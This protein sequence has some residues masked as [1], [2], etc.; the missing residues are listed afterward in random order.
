[1][2]LTEFKAS[3]KKSKLL[4]VIG[5]ISP[6]IPRKLRNIPQLFVDGGCKLKK[7]HTY[8]SPDSFSLGDGDSHSKNLLDHILPSKKDYSDFRF[9]LSIIQSNLKEIYLTGFLGKRMD[10]E[11]VNFGEVHSFLAAKKGTVVN[12]LSKNRIKI[13]AYSNGKYDFNRTGNFSLLTLTTANVT[14][15][16]K[17]E[18]KILKKRPLPVLSSLGLSN[19]GFGKIK[20]KTNRPIFVIFED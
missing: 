9:A 6:Q 15:S 5:P 7:K 3:L 18:Y 19:I 17:C 16:G 12:F 4:L 14:L 11:L 20:L 1:M 13:T 10:H 2:N 8:P